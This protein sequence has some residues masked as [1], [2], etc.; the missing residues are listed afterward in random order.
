[1]KPETAYSP[2]TI[3]KERSQEEEGEHGCEED[4]NLADGTF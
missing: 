3:P 1:M 2:I 4:V